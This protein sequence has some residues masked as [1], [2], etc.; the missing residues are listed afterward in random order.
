ME[1]IRKIV[2]KSYKE[3]EM[4]TTDS[5]IGAATGLIAVGIIANVAGKMMD[6]DSSKKKKKKKK[7]S[8]WDL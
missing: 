5:L 2:K 8:I 3:D 4:T 6:D 7:G 1:N